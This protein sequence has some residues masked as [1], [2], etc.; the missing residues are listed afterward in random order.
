MKRKSFHLPFD[1]MTLEKWSRTHRLTLILILPVL[2]AGAAFTL[3]HWDV[4]ASQLFET[5]VVPVTGE[6]HN[7]A[8]ASSLLAKATG[9]H[10]NQATLPQSVKLAASNCVY[11]DGWAP[12]LVSAAD[13][14]PRLSITYGIAIAELLRANCLDRTALILPG[15]VIYVPDLISDV[16]EPPPPT[17]TQTPMPFTP[18]ILPV[19]NNINHEPSAPAT[20]APIEAT[21]TTAPQPPVSE[22]VP[23][24]T[25]A[26]PPP[27]NTSIPPVN[28]AANK[29]PHVKPPEPKNQDTPKPHIDPPKKQDPPKP[30]NSSPGDKKGKKAK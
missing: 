19:K 22:P 9:Q 20:S 5:P 12:Y 4:V 10:N 1:R 26:P 14:L 28:N 21:P 30:H 24:P 18:A 16:L 3:S 11:P 6:N 13:S 17:P 15:Q 8:V 25:V 23:P 29:K 27:A 7:G 2:L